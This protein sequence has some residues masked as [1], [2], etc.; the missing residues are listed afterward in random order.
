MGSIGESTEDSGAQLI[1]QSDE[2]GRVPFEARHPSVQRKLDSL[3]VR[4]VRLQRFTIVRFL[5]TFGIL[6]GQR[7]AFGFS[8]E[9][10]F[11]ATF[12]LPWLILGGVSAL[13]SVA[14][15]AGE[16]I[17]KD[18]KSA[19]LD[20][21]SKVLTQETIDSYLAPLLDEVV[22]GSTGLTIIGFIV[23]LWSGSRVFA[24]FV[25]G[26][27]L[28]NGSPKRNYLETRGLAL[29]IYALGLLTLAALVFS[30]VKWPDAWQTAFG[31]LPGGVSFWFGVSALGLSA[32]AAT[33]MM[34]L[35]NP[36]RTRWWYAL[37]GGLVGLVLWLAGSWGLQTYMSWL[38]REGSLYGAIAAPIA[39]MLWLFVGT[40]AMFVG[41]TLNAAVLYFLDVRNH[42][43]AVL[44]SRAESALI[45]GRRLI[46]MA[47]HPGAKL[48]EKDANAVPSQP[49]EPDS[50]EPTPKSDTT[51]EPGR[52]DAHQESR[53]PRDSADPSERR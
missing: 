28:I 43:L 13:S 36:R 49:T 32:L 52:Q 12:T 34:W 8:A 39:I 47:K 25:E 21:A 33:T 31:I 27:A 30:V 9:A 18:L 48:E 19:V 10:A 45:T 17:D 37:P 26:S 7:R 24:T 35:A 38:L 46:R 6:F 20:A 44:R 14:R 15:A 41:I 40:L 53:E 29:T 50:S 4:W 1:D 22:A 42:D 5:G 51:D 23:A 2:H 3:G 11:W 16:N